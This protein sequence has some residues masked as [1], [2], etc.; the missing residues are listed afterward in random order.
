M[1]R[2]FARVTGWR[3][4]Y[5]S[6]IY[7]SLLQQCKGKISAPRVVALYNCL[8]DLFTAIALILYVVSVWLSFRD[9]DFGP[10]RREGWF[11]VSTPGAPL[12]LSVEHINRSCS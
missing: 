7:F 12:G 1:Q 11:D 4:T 8:D 9:F 6:S 3:G 2:C 10:F 5:T